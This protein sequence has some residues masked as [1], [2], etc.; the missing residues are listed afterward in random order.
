MRA[1]R[2]PP[3]EFVVACMTLGCGARTSL[4]V[5]DE[6]APIALDAGAPESGQAMPSD[7]A[8]STADHD[9]ALDASSSDG[10]TSATGDATADA[11]EEGLP[12]SG[13]SPSTCDGCCRRDGSCVA[14]ESQTQAFCGSGGNLCISCP[15]ACGVDT[16][17]GTRVCGHFL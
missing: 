16:T 3:L 1:G 15:V 13:C 11:A 7:D 17:D 8:A 10:T 14:P 4:L 6:I 12:D 9:E 5:D 2:R